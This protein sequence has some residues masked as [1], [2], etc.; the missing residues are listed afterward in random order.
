MISSELSVLHGEDRLAV[1]H[2]ELLFWV[3]AAAGCWNLSVIHSSEHEPSRTLAGIIIG[4]L[5]S[6][7]LLGE[8]REGSKVST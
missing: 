1:F 5:C 4:G 7:R 6:F 8:L 3:E 2:S